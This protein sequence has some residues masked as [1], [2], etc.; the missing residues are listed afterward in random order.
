LRRPHFINR[1]AALWEYLTGKTRLTAYPAEV[2][3]E[4]TNKCN[5]DCVF[6]PHG[7]MKRPQ[8]F[9]RADLFKKVVDEIAGKAETVALDLMGEATLHPEIGELIRYA[10]GRRLKVA[11][12]SN[13]VAVTPETMRELADAG[14]D[15]LVMNL[16][17]ATRETYEAMRRGADFQRTKE[18]IEAFLKM[19]AKGVTTVVQMVYT[20][21]NRSEADD[22][23]KM[24]KDSGVDC[25]RLR[26]YQ[27]VDREKTALNAMPVSPRRRGACIRPWKKLSVYWDG[28]AVMCCYDYD[29][30]LA[31]GDANT[32]GV[33]SIWNNDRMRGYRAAFIKGDL[34]DIPL[35]RTCCYFV[36]GSVLLLGSLFADSVRVR[37]VLCV[38]ERLWI[39]YRTPL[40]RYYAADKTP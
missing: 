24:W 17:G 27:N 2:A 18:N 4:L 37:K 19:E 22:F 25:V 36:P 12:N 8:G 34:K 14:L 10:K 30:H 32:E 28:T 1:A 39:K 7:K 13:M 15:I 3:L 21:Q 23:L 9:M 16:D 31:V 5:V 33:L 20:T 35:C 40:F 29:G 26:P 11:L 38:L 6:C